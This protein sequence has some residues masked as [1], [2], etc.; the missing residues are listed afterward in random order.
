MSSSGMWLCVALAKPDAW[1]EGIAFSITAK[2]IR[3]RKGTLAV[4]TRLNRG[5]RTHVLG[6]VYNTLDPDL[7]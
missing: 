5:T 7:L 3:N 4:T 6:S 1:E 2:I